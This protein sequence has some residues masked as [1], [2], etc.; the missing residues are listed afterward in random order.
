MRTPV[1]GTPFSISLSASEAMKTASVAPSLTLAPDEI[2]KTLSYIWMLAPLMLETLCQQVDRPNC[3][4]SIFRAIPAIAPNIYL[5]IHDRCGCGER[6]ARTCGEV[7]PVGAS[8]TSV[9]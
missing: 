9:W 6:V 1:R 3:T 4:D 5:A 8:L 2:M 7:F